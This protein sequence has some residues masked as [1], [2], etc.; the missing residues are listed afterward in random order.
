MEDYEIDETTLLGWTVRVQAHN[1]AEASEKAQRIASW[2]D[3]WSSL[4]TVDGAQHR[5]AGC[6]VTGFVAE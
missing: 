1:E 4:A 5:I 6:R 3:I 2:I